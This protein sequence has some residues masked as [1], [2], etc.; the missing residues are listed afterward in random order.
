MP[1]DSIGQYEFLALHG[2]PEGPR[3]MLEVLSRA[4][5]DGLA[6]WRTGVRGRPFTLRSSVDLVSLAEA[7][8]CFSLYQQLV[9]ENIVP[10]VW[11]G[12]AF[13]GYGWQVKVLDV[14][15]VSARAVIGVV[16]GMSPPSYGWLV[17]DWELV[18]VQQPAA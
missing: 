15:L 11:G 1:Y 8:Y 7:H 2:N 5:V 9:G 4:G 17:A 16:G 10:L 13:T 14:R 18:A 12:I 6:F 3:E